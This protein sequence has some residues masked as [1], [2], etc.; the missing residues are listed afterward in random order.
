MDGDHS[1]IVVF[2]YDFVTAAAAAVVVVVVDSTVLVTLRPVSADAK[3]L[4]GIGLRSFQVDQY[5]R[6]LLLLAIHENSQTMP[7]MELTPC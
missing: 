6:L 2:P 7:K 4:V 5:I 3:F 1:W